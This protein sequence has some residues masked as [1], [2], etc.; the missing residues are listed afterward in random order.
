MHHCPTKKGVIRTGLGSGPIILH[1]EL[2]FRGPQRNTNMAPC[3]TTI[4][5]QTFDV[6]PAPRAHCQPPLKTHL[7]VGFDWMRSSTVGALICFGDFWGMFL[8]REY[9]STLYKRTHS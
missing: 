2:C 3:A 5:N 7:F 1:V 8:T 6:C 9:A 4:W